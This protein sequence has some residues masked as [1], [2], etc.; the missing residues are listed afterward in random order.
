MADLQQSAN[1]FIR[2][3]SANIGMA[4]LHIDVWIYFAGYILLAAFR[5]V[6]PQLSFLA[7]NST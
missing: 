7:I 6:P 2:Q 3:A 5:S 4:A 1:L